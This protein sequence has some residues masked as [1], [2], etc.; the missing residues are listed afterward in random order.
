MGGTPEWFKLAFSNTDNIKYC[1]PA[2]TRKCSN[3][4]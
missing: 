1:Q 3:G 4:S 2:E